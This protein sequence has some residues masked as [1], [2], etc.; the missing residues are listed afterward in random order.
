MSALL[1]QN[2]LYQLTSN[3]N[4]IKILMKFTPPINKFKAYNHYILIK[5]SLQNKKEVY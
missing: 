5:I 3:L 2:P 4:F 1:I